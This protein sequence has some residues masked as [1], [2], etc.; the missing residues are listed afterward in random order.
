MLS[1]D[2][3]ISAETEKAP[4]QRAVSVPGRRAPDERVF[5]STEDAGRKAR[6]QGVDENTIKS[7]S[8]AQMQA[9]CKANGIQYCKLTNDGM[10]K[11]LRSKLNERNDYARERLPDLPVEKVIK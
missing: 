1:N 6:P 4:A 10:R 3:Q 5:N 11:A 7:A 8:K 9:L 2:M